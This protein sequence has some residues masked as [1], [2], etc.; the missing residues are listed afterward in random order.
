MCSSRNG[1]SALRSP[2]WFQFSLYVRSG[3][4]FWCTQLTEI[5][6]PDSFDLNLL[7]SITLSGV[8]ISHIAHLSSAYV[9]YILAKGVYVK[10]SASGGRVALGAALLHIISPAGV[11]LSA[12][13]TE[14]LFS[15]LNISGF[16]LYLRGMTRTHGHATVIQ[17]LQ[18]VFAGFVFGVATTIRSNGLLSGLPFLYDAFARTWAV[19]NHGFSSRR[20]YDL[21]SLIIG[22]LL[23]ACGLVMPQAF[24][25]RMYCVDISDV[26]RQPWCSKAI[27]SIYGWVQAHYW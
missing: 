16:A 27:P 26:T 19:I 14:S 7:Q 17:R 3:F 25:Y 13:Y 2:K 1:P 10:P 6:L 9:V 8:G 21:T 4:V 23:V 24:A 18:L 12:P 15:L 11:F 22:G 5:G 20:L